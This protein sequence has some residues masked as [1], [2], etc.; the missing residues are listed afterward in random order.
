ME[1]GESWSRLGLIGKGTTRGVVVFRQAVLDAAGWSPLSGCSKLC[2][3]GNFRPDV[4]WLLDELAS[5][6]KVAVSYSQSIDP[7]P[8]DP[9]GAEHS[10]GVSRHTR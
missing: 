6:E 9:L 7:P 10:G 1:G 2:V 5:D 3:T 4:S 8:L